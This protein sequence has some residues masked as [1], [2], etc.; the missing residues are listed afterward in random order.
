MTREL[1]LRL[2]RDGL[3]ER[4]QIENAMQAQ[5]IYEGS[6][7]S[8]LLRLGYVHEPAILNYLGAL[9]GLPLVRPEKLGEVSAKILD[10]VPRD[11]IAR[12][13]FLPLGL[14]GDTL[15]IAVHD[16]LDEARQA[17]LAAIMGL[18]IKQVLA[19][20]AALLAAI[21]RHVAMRLPSQITSDRAL[22]AFPDPRETDEAAEEAPSAPRAAAPVPTPMVAPPPGAT[23]VPVMTPVFAAPRPV[24]LLES[25]IAEADTR[26]AII[27]AACTWLGRWY[28][29][30]AFLT[31][32][33]AQAEGFFAL[34]DDAHLAPFKALTFSLTVEHA[35][36]LATASGEVRRVPEGAS[37]D[38]LARIAQALGADASSETI[39]VPLAVKGK[40]VGLLVGLSPAEEAAPLADA[41]LAAATAALSS[42]LE[43]LILARKI[44]I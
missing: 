6:L 43:A 44:G 8:N 41:D 35:L 29:G 13:R 32:K 22:I 9:Y 19:P 17:A 37:D 26:D 3:I 18:K 31:V 42:S 23:G 15:V 4:W 1:A 10:L 7:L 33:R 24:S 39:V 12:L 14:Q 11:V 27:Q 40:T 28:R 16:P 30:A 20:E 34:G 25:L 36:S 38:A 5:L 21:L 2:S